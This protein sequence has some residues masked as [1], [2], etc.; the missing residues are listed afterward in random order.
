M[1]RS[2]LSVSGVSV[3]VG[4]TAGTLKAIVSDPVGYVKSM[5]KI[6]EVVKQ[7]D[8]PVRLLKAMADGFEQQMRV[9]NPYDMEDQRAL[10]EEFRT[11]YY[12][13]MVAFEVLKTAAG[14]SA[15]K[16][17]KS[18]QKLSKVISKVILPMLRKAGK[19]L[20]LGRQCQ[21]VIH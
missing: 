10:Y 2:K 7:L 14:A 13:G 11:S 20:L 6:V 8:H 5:A 15:T 4:Q 9:A 3:G 17:A 1:E 19:L 16:A 18:I 21:L 12:M